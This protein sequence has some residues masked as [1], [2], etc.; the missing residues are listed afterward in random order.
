MG[1][2]GCSRPD[3][4]AN[5]KPSEGT[6][7]YFRD[8]YLGPKRQDLMESCANGRRINQEG[9]FYFDLEKQD[10]T[11]KFM[12]SKGTS[13]KITEAITSGKAA[14]MAVACPEVR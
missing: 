4:P 3:A 12:L 10:E 8:I 11:M 14:A 2:S 6:W 7:A 5:G 9:G 1:A 13:R